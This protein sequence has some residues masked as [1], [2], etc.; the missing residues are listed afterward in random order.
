MQLHVEKKPESRDEKL[1]LLKSGYTPEKRRFEICTLITFTILWVLT[2]YNI[3]QQGGFNNWALN[4]VSLLTG[5]LVA[6]FLSGV[7]HWYFDTYGTVNT[8]VIGVLIRSFREHHINPKAMCDHDFI[9]VSADNCIIPIPFLI[10]CAIW[11]V[12]LSW[13][14]EMFLMCSTLWTVVFVLFTNQVHKWAHM[15]DK[16]RPHI[17]RVLQK[18]GFILRSKHHWE[19]H[20]N[21]YDH[22]YCI[23]NGWCN[24]FLEK[25]DFWKKVENLIQ[26]HTGHI[27]R[28]DDLEWTKKTP[29]V[30]SPAEPVAP[31]NKK[32]E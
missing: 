26:K 4:A 8:P 12:Q 6:D 13:T 15:S 9:E 3:T 7:V 24:P 17:V 31:S 22:N 29:S 11:Q 14:I 10:T 20:L 23:F 1:E 2:A 27:A 30:D 5:I 19:H 18:S 25:I 21:P 32:E 28:N 16:F